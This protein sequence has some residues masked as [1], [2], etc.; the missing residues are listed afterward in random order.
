[1]QTTRRAT[2]GRAVLIAAFAAGA[3][4]LAASA[5]ASAQVSVPRDAPPPE[6]GE[7]PQA[8]SPRGATYI[9][10]VGFRLAPPLGPR[11][12]GY[13]YGPRVYGWY[14]DRETR[15]YYRGY[16]ARR[17]ACDPLGALFGERCTRRWR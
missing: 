15:R 13:Y 6:T 16:R 9:P 2:S 17:V 5:G 11:V 3:G 4:L 14:D 1:M 12:Y 10:G 7:V 8:A